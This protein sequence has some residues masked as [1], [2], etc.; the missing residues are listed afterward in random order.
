MILIKKPRGKNMT[1]SLIRHIFI[2]FITLNSQLVAQEI[3]ESEVGYS[4]EL[5]ELGGLSC[6]DTFNNKN[7]IKTEEVIQKNPNKKIQAYNDFKAG[8]NIRGKSLIFIG[9]GI[10]DISAKPNDPNY[11]DA[12]QN[13]VVLAGLR[14][15]TALTEYR[16]IEIKTET[17]NRAMEAISS[18]VPVSDYGKRQDKLEQRE[19]DYNDKSID[20]KLFMFIDRKLDEWVGEKQAIAEDTAQLEKELENVL[21]QTVFEE[22]ITTLS[23]SEISGMKDAQIQINKDKVCVIS[24]WTDRTK[25][26]ANELAELNY[27]A[28]ANLRPGSNN[29]KDLIP[30]KKDKAGLESL[31]GLYGLHI[32]SD[33]NGELYIISYAQ[34]SAIDRSASSI[35]NA[36]IIAET[37]ARG[38]IAK[39]QDEAVDINRN[40]ENIEIT[41]AY[42]DG[43]K[44]TYSER[45]F[46]EKTKAS[47]VLNI[48]G[49]EQHDWWATIHPFSQKPVIGSILVWQPSFAMILDE[50]EETDDYDYLDF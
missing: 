46:M 42:T 45:N 20:Q 40:L 37:R 12:V 27:K 50:S 26:W 5:I 49:I 43:I 11:I 34:A 44:N 29:Y 25:R 32:G 41:T 19:K 4:G 33:K 48:A 18:G 2:I 7:R 13:S 35:N 10:A 38:Q 16:S 24:V 23:Y 39:F 21:S 3:S 22:I 8:K 9:E 1:L 31:I 15:K 36:R 17:I 28:L 14:A 30:S 47:S 6:L